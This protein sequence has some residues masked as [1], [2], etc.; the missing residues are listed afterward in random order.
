[1]KIKKKVNYTYIKPSLNTML[2][3]YD[4]FIKEYKN[5][6]NNHIIIDFSEFI[7]IKTDELLLFLNLIKTH[8]KNKFS[9]ILVCPTAEIDELPYELSVVP[10]ILEAEDLI[11]IDNIERELG[12]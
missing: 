9:F 7:N 1:M 11:E 2:N 3:F 5:I 8:K 12:F 6:N 4:L 10:T